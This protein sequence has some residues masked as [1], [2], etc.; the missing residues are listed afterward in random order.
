MKKSTVIITIL[1]VLVGIVFFWYTGVYN[2]LVSME[3]TVTA[4]WGNV[5]NQYQRRSDLIPNLV[6]TVKGYANHEQATLQGVVEA[7]AKA[8][9]VSIDPTNMTEESMAQFQAA[10]GQVSSSLSRLLVSIEAYPDLKANQ[11]FMDLQAQL[12]QTE[13]R[14]SVQ[15]QRFND[16]AQEY[17]ALVRKFPNNMIANMSGFNTKPYFKSDAGAER[18]PEVQF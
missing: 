9:S 18:A 15:R 12:E 11:N 2:K 10:Q 4:Q 14:I 13:N 5:E 8:T 7:R 6:S 3:E 16:V 1:V 17:N